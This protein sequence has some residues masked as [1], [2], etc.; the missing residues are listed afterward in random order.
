ML[1][2]FHIPRLDIKNVLQT[3]HSGLKFVHKFGPLKKFSTQFF[4][5]HF[6]VLIFFVIF[7]TQK[8]SHHFITSGFFTTVLKFLFRASLSKQL[9]PS[10]FVLYPLGN[11][12][13]TWKLR[14][15]HFIATEN[16]LYFN[17]YFNL[18]FY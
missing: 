13:G 15:F 16:Y 12:L 4:W 1:A 10:R 14:P 6:L 7:L 2:D 8:S 18:Y 3:N 9:F 5:K 11:L 17:I